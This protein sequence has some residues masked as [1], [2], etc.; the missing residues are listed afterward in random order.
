[1]ARRKAE[2]VEQAFP[3]E[4]MDAE[5]MANARALQAQA[6]RVRSVARVAALNATVATMQAIPSM[7]DRAAINALA[8][9]V[10]DIARLMR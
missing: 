8:E 4:E 7:T 3:T 5:S 9:A 6:E 10:A 1:M 2:V